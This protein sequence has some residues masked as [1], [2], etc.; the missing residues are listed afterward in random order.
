VAALGVALYRPARELPGPGPEALQALQRSRGVV[1]SVAELL[2][3]EY[4]VPF[5]ITAVLL[6][7]ALVGALYLAKRR[8]E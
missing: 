6:T 3:S 8:P 1:G 7:V 5:E 2:F 4:L